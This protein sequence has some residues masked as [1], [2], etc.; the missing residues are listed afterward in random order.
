MVVEYLP[1]GPL[2]AR[3]GQGRK[4]KLSQA[5]LVTVAL[6]D[7]LIYM[8]E[9]GITHCDLNPSNVLFDPQGRPKLVD[10]G[11]AHVSD[12]FVHRSWYTQ[13]SV[14]MGTVYYIAPEQLDGVRDDPRVDMYA[15]AAMFY[16]MLS[17][18]H[19]VDFDL[20]STPSAQAEN[21]RR[22]H[23]EVPVPIPDI[24]HEINQ[25]ILCAL[26]KHPG[27]RYPDTTVFR[28]R[29]I[30]SLFPYLPPD[31]GL[32]LVAPFRS[33]AEGR[34]APLDAADWPRWVW[35]VLL[36]INLIAMIVFA[37]LLFGSS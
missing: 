26:A 10:L 4:L 7:A 1:G 29:L 32:H 13:R 11:I 27:D 25:V 34:P 35:G 31:R 3:V 20:A 2:S 19:Y 9:R 23:Q 5:A 18:R 28:R 17:G 15:V 14:A 12:G 30:R 33:R 21:I 16:E 24:P 8:H 36:V 6:C 22:V 37:L